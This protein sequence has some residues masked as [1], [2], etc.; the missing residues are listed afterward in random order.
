MYKI[1]NIA[2]NDKADQSKCFHCIL[3]GA[4]KD[5]TD[6]NLFITHTTEKFY[7]DLITQGN[8]IPDPITLCNGESYNSFATAI[9]STVSLIQV[10]VT[11]IQKHCTSDTQ[12]FWKLKE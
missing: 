7:T 6:K 11:L 3:Q 2:I 10:S 8:K 9:R 1:H 12:I 5:R 4:N